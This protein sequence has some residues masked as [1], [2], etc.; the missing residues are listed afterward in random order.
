MTASAQRSLSCSPAISA[1]CVPFANARPLSS[2]GSKRV[3]A[4]GG[5]AVVRVEN[6]FPV[7]GVQ[8]R[9]LDVVACG[10]KPLDRKIPEC[11]IQR[12]GFGVGMDEQYIHGR[13]S[14]SK[15]GSR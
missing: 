4:G 13:G 2:D 5:G 15:R 6:G 12:S 8:V 14:I 1:V 7:H 11:A 3:P 9:Q 10:F